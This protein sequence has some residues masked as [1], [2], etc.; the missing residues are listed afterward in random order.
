MRRRDVLAVVSSA[1]MFR[2]AGTRA[3]TSGRRRRIGVLMGY[4]ESDAGA[5]TRVAVF[6]EGLQTLGWTEGVNVEIE[7]RWTAGD[8][9]RTSIMAR[10]LVSLTP[11]VI[12]SNSTP[13]TAA[14]H[15]ET[16][17]IPIVFVIVSDPVGSGFVETLAR[18]GTNI[19]GFI[20]IDA[21]VAEKWPE[22]LKTIAPKVA[23]ISAMFNPDTA[24][25]AA[26]YLQPMESVASSLGIEIKQAPVRSDTEIENVIEV[27]GQ[28]SNAGLIIMT[29]SFMFVHRKTINASTMRYKVP[30]IHYASDLVTEGGLISYGVET[31]DLFRRAAPYV[32]RI[33]R[34][35]NPADLPVQQPT[36]F[37]LAINLS[38]AKALGL[39]VPFSLLARADEVIE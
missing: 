14:L 34:G 12:L 6:K 2:P 4:D 7:I 19:T 39:T 18:P 20:N 21:S 26:F 23:Q 33:L 15:R 11:D 31:I 25:F 5:Q 17:S 24:P 32:D 10:E 22:L 27:L 9:H 35:A 36:Q 37:E 3:D 30:A 13:V 8:I 29:D 28:K 38:T 16:R 1:V